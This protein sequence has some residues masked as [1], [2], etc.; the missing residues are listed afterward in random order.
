MKKLFVLAFL[1]IFII[2]CGSDELNPCQISI[3]FIKE[4][5]KNPA[6]LDYSSFDCTKEFDNVN[7]YT[8]LR[9]VSAENSFGVKKEFIYKLELKYLGGNQYDKSS[10]ELISLKSEE[11]R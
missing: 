9:K 10:W 11:Y 8:I 2:S 4:D 7:K 3:D 6:T 1:S 5:L